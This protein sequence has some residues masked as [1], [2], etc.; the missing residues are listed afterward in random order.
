[1]IYWTMNS[2]PE[3]QGLEKREKS[4][5]FKEMFKQGRSRLG[6]AQLLTRILIFAAI[7][8]LAYIFLLPMFQAATAGMGMIGMFLLCGLIGGLVAIPAIMLIQT[9]I[10]D[11]GREWLREQG[12][13]KKA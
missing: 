9:P 10:I 3:L 4:R 12:Y 8:G 1:M 6:V 13:P 2:V 7:V 11:R 5:V